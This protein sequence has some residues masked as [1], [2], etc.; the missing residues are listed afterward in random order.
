MIR[1][2][3]SVSIVSANLNNA[4]FLKDY[5]DSIL[6]SSVQPLEIIL[7]EDGST[8]NSLQVINKYRYID[9]L[10][11][12]VNQENIGFSKSLNKGI[13]LAKGKY[14]MRLDPDD[15][16]SC[17]RIEKQYNFLENNRAIDLVGSNVNY[18][19]HQLKRVVFTSC[20]PQTSE[21]IREQYK[22]GFHG[23]IH[24]TIMARRTIFSNYSYSQSE[25]PAEEYDLFSRMV[26][27]E[28]KMANL[29]SPLTNYRL[30]ENNTSHLLFKRALIKTH[31]LR[32][33]IFN[34]KTNNFS[35][36]IKTRHLFYYRMALMSKSDSMRYLYFCLALIF[37]PSKLIKRLRAKF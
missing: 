5:F 31:K 10:K 25:I 35:L 24:S 7:V 23:V 6:N 18:F 16:I 17:E 4:E 33:K 2:I 8:D 26:S 15:F 19:N 34:K 37:H 32:E 20:F 1:R 14:V 22:K 12:I 9:F 36:Y 13:N 3:V 27:G 11:V 30:H 21:E 28:I 29:S